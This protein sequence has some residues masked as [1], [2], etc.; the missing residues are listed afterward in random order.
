MTAKKPPARRERDAAIDRSASVDFPA[1][2]LKGLVEHNDAAS[3]FGS[4]G[5]L[6]TWLAIAEGRGWITGVKGPRVV[7]AAGRKHYDESGLEQL[8]KI[9]DRRAYMWNWSCYTAEPGR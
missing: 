1:A 5:A 9:R 7:T 4:T 8:P 3:Y 6:L 2:V